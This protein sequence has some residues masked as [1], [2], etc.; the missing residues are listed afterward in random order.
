MPGPGSHPLFWNGIAYSPGEADFSKYRGY[1]YEIGIAYERFGP[2][3]P[4]L[5]AA[6]NFGSAANV[7]ILVD[8][9]CTGNNQ[10]LVDDIWL[11]QLRAIHIPET[12]F[13]YPGRPAER[14]GTDRD[15]LRRRR[16]GPTRWAPG[17][18]DGATYIRILQW[19]NQTGGWVLAWPPESVS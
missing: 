3:L 12:V 8:D 17:H 18:Y 7:G 5:T 6:G 10:H 2:F 16:Y 14:D 19:S 1:L 13:T 15:E 4:D 11:P 9:D